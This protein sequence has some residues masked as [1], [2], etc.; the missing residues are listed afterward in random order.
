MTSEKKKQI[1]LR[2]LEI[3][4]A[5][6]GQLT[7]DAVVADARDPGS[8][9]H[10]QFE[11]DVGKAAYKYWLDQARNL[12][13]SVKVVATVDKQQ[14][15]T[16]FY[17][18]DPRAEHDEQGYVSLTTLKSDEDLAREAIHAEFLRA[19]AVMHRAKTLAAVLSLTEQVEE[20]ERQISSLI[21]LTRPAV[22]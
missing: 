11:W 19:R 7:P 1:R 3:C 13:T 6:D 4:A 12:I 18:R 20:A 15:S 8:P 2:L 10:D 17:V 21:Q 14:V 16:V 5:N 22:V 9:L